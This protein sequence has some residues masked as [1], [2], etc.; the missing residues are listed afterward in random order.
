MDLFKE[1]N[2]NCKYCGNLLNLKNQRDI[3]RKNFCSRKC[4]YDWLHSHYKNN[5]PCPE[6]L[7]EKLRKMFTIL[8][9]KEI[10]RRRC[11]SET[12]KKKY[13]LGINPCGFKKGHKLPH[14]VGYKHT[15]KWKED[16]RERALKN[17]N[18]LNS[19]LGKHQT[20]HQK[21]M[22]RKAQLGEKNVSKRQEVR[23]K[24]SK[25]KRKAIADGFEVKC[26]KFG[27][28]IE[29]KIQLFLKELQIEFKNN[30]YIPIKDRYRADI[31]IPEQEGITQKTVIECDGDYWHGNLE[32]YGSWN[33]LTLKQKL[34]K[35]RDFERT[36]QL[37]KEG[38]LVLRLWEKHIEKM[39][40]EGFQKELNQKWLKEIEDGMD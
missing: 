24:L 7:K 38:Y 27:T 35:I 31:F 16:A 12:H 13:A 6:H 26:G 19:R 28:K 5:N 18:F 14:V 15:E 25:I 10:E 39:S 30:H 32:K 33:N 37:E 17:T 29:V 1:F 40:L 23:A 20:N 11:I 22:A 2:K 21:E 3:T 36:A 8:N 9:K 4:L 34:T